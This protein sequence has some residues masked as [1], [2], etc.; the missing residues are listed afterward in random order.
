MTITR[1]IRN[2][3]VPALK[4]HL[5]EYLPTF[6]YEISFCLKTKVIGKVP[7]KM[8]YAFLDQGRGK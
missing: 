4:R 5:S 7:L 1:Y 2:D 6:H 8:L 3:T